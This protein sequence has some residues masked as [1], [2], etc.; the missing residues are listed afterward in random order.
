[1]ESID[2]LNYKIKSI[3]TGNS[4]GNEN[5]KDKNNEK[6]TEPSHNEN[7][8]NVLVQNIPSNLTESSLLNYFGIYG[9]INSHAIVRRR[10]LAFI[11][12]DDPQSAREAIAYKN[13]FEL[14]GQTI[15]CKLSNNKFDRSKPSK[16]SNDANFRS[17]YTHH[18]PRAQPKPRHYN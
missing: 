11:N 8:T 14:E 1:M 18:R 3:V 5:S 15:N 6:Q 12:Y 7:L 10:N 4:N 16:F 9:N 17:K 2:Q 13:N